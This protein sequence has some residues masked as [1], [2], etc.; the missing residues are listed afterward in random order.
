[1]EQLKSH[2]DSP[3]Y[4]L[5]MLKIEAE[6][7]CLSLQQ[8]TSHYALDWLERCGLTHTDEASLNRMAEHIALARVL[9][10]CGRLEEALYL[11]G[12]LYALLC[13]EDR[14]RGRIE[15]LI[16][17]SL[18]LQRLCQTEAALVQLETALHLAEPEG[19]IRSFIDEGPIMGE[20]L[21]AYLKVKQGSHLRDTPSVS[22]AYVRQ[23]LQALNV[24]PEEVLS[25]KEILTEQETRVLLLITNGLS[26]KEIA[27][28]LNITTET[29]KSHI[30]NVYR[31]LGVNN[32]IQALQHAKLLKILA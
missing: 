27:H 18:T 23:L 12:R 15:V 13:K 26:N 29:V 24:T 31:K 19:Y 6:Q 9:A 16:L 14:L 20:L 11:L 2:I 21:S 4:V 22:S 32:R 5:F 28:R 17:Q 30:K 7:A 10:E 25:L 8:G 3:D 1:L